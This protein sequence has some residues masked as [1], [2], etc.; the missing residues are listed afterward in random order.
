[1]SHSETPPPN[2]C[3]A[4]IK[5]RSKHCEQ[6]KGQGTDHPGSGHCKW[7]FGS[8][9]AGREFA[10][11]EAGMQILKYTTPL[12]ID[13]TAA[14]LQELYRTA[15]QVRYLDAK[16]GEWD[17][18]TTEEI[19]DSQKQWLAV[20]RAE[21][22]HMAAVAKLALDAGVA[23][24]EIQLAEQQGAILADAIEKILD[25]MQL[26]VAQINLIP[27]VV[28]AVLRAVSVRMDDRGVSR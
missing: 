6:P 15:G 20:H 12:E 2:V 13:P 26:T 19:P 8:T 14:L 7:H 22:K 3:G 10:A 17:L 11:K 25:R 23:E 21:R 27:E 1:M 18:D 5:R 4:W 28:P 24:R 16:I 9:Q